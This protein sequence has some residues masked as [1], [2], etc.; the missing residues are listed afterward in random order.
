ML[1]KKKN[2]IWLFEARIPPKKKRIKFLIKFWKTTRIEK[3]ILYTINYK[4]MYKI[5]L[6]FM[7]QNKKIYIISFFKL[8]PGIDLFDLF[9]HCPQK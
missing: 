1:T 4:N 7:N 9:Y 3:G 5:N 8:Q 6:T 2:K